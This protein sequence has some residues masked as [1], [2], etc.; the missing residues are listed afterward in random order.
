MPLAYIESAYNKE[1]QYAENINVYVSV[2]LHGD[3]A[4]S[5][6]DIS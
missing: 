2:C 4:S 6:T 3:S 1:E 5:S